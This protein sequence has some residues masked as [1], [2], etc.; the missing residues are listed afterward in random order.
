MERRN[1]F[2]VKLLQILHYLKI[3]R[4]IYIHIGHK[5]HARQLVLLTDLP[6]LLCAYLNACFTGNNDDR[7]VR[8]S[9]C[10]LNLAHKIK[11]S[12][13]I[14]NIYLASFPFDGNNGCTDGKR[15]LDLFFV[16]IADCIA[17][18]DLSHSG[19]L[20]GQVR[21]RFYQAGLT[22]PSMA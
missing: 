21:H 10:L 14:Q 4:V 20:T 18:T 13:R 16:K 12:G 7:C 1:L 5:K 3:V 2:A 6:C 15:A 17:F 9:R 11:V 19:R 8:H 22:R